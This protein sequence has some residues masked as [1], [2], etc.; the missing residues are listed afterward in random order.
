MMQVEGIPGPYALECAAGDVDGV[1]HPH[2]T[3][4]TTGA[5]VMFHIVQGREHEYLKIRDAVR[6]RISQMMPHGASLTVR[7]IGDQNEA[8]FCD[9]MAAGFG[10]IFT[11][12][13]VE[14]GSRMNMLNAIAGLVAKGIEYARTNG[15]PT[16]GESNQ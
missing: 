4:G 7:R 6:I 12:A 16:T 13:G 1:C 8:G 2:A 15:T 5:S 3:S 11:D 14:D 9:R 10:D